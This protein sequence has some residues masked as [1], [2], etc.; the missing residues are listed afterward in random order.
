MVDAPAG[1]RLREV[2]LYAHNTSPHDV[3][4]TVRLWSSHRGYG[5]GTDRVLGAL[6]IP[7]GSALGAVRLELPEDEQGPYPG[8]TKPCLRLHTPVDGTVQV[9]GA[10]FGFSGGCLETA[11]LPAPRRVH[12]TQ[13]AGAGGI[14]RA[15]RT[16]TIAL[17]DSVI[18]PF[19]AGVI[20]NLTALRG[21]RAGVLRA[22]PAGGA[23]RRRRPCS[24]RG[25][26]WPGRTRWWCRSRRTA[27]S[28]CGPPPTCTC[29]STWSG[30]SPEGADCRR[31]R[32][33]PPRHG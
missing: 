2:E 8:G 7:P 11:L 19:T 12:D 25:R 23:V 18:T 10:R 33:V 17:P 31:G 27:G 20:V 9:T 15:G 6:T 26:T 1:A 22:F 13:D 28:R 29:A 21:A 14:L 3:S 24:S 5:D 16:R 32:R 4:A 30:R